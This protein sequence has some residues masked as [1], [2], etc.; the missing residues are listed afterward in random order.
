M[1][2]KNTDEMKNRIESKSGEKDPGVIELILLKRV[3]GINHY[4]YYF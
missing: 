3:C 4:Y 1:N 2:K